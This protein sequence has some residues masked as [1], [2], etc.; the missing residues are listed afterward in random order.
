MTLAVQRFSIKNPSLVNFPSLSINQKLPND[1]LLGVLWDQ[2][3]MPQRASSKIILALKIQPQACMQRF[4]CLLF[5]YL[6]CGGENKQACFEP[7]IAKFS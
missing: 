4:S 3:I 1:P 7:T 5:C 6:F 2:K